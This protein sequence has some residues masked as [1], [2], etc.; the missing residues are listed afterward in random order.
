MNLA[1][2]LEIYAGGPGS[3]CQGPNCGRKPSASAI[4]KAEGIEKQV[5]DPIK[6]E[7]LRRMQWGLSE[8]QKETLFKRQEFGLMNLARQMEDLP[9]DEQQRSMVSHFI[10]KS[11]SRQKVFQSDSDAGLRLQ[12]GMLSHLHQVLREVQGKDL[13]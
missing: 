9:L 13:F 6:N 4:H 3:G 10:K 1:T 8:D 2:A 12:D 7:P 5:H 11:A